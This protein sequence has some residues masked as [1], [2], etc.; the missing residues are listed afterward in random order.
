MLIFPVKSPFSKAILI[1]PIQLSWTRGGEALER[2]LQGAGVAVRRYPQSQGQE[3][4][5]RFTGA[6]VKR[7]PTFE[8]R[9]PQQDGRCWSRGCVVL[10]QLWGDTPQP[11]AKEKP[12]QDGRRGE[13]DLESNLIP[14]RDAQRAQTNLVHNRTQGPHRDWDRNVLEHL[15]W[16]MG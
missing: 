3:L 2:W 9:K 15:L 14:A 11:R 12:Q 13:F 10:E 5:P 6:A 1:Y 8:V 4:W 16:R 7:Q